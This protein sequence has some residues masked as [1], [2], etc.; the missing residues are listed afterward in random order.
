MDEKYY[1][2]SQDQLNKIV[3]KIEP[4]TITNA[5]ADGYISVDLIDLTQ[6]FYNS[7][8]DL[9]IDALEKRI[10]ELENRLKPFIPITQYE[11]LINKGASLE[12]INRM[13]N[14]VA[15]LKQTIIEMKLSENK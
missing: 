1:R 7:Q 15:E 13:T 4:E 12:V 14:E 6:K 3:P 5:D 11:M 9:R 2:P 10:S 8:F